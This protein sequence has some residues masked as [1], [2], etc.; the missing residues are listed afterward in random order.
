MP[1][2]KKEQNFE[3]EKI[4]TLTPPRTAVAMRTKAWTKGFER[5]QPSFSNNSRPNSRWLNKEFE[6]ICRIIFVFSKYSWT[7]NEIFTF[8]LLTL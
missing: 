6:W 8:R 5:T 3:I 4:K 2:Q 1:K 7:K